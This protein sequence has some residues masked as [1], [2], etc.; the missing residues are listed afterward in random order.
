MSNWLPFGVLLGAF[1]IILGAFG[2]ILGTLGAIV[3]AFGVHFDIY[4]VPK[5]GLERE[6]RH[7]EPTRL[8]RLSGNP[9]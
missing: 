1:G 6:R 4:F 5:K 8:K 3:G 7:R 9:R 2:V